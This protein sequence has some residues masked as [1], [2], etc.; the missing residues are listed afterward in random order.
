MPIKINQSSNAPEQAAPTLERLKIDYVPIDSVQLWKDNPREN[1]KAVPELMEGIKRHGLRTPLVVWGKNRYIYKGNTTWK[2]LRRLGYKEVPVILTSFK[3][4]AAAVDYGIDD[5]K[6]G[7]KAG[8]NVDLLRKLLVSRPAAQKPVSFTMK[9][10]SVLQKGIFG[11]M[12][13]KDKIPK[14]EEDLDTFEI[15]VSVPPKDKDRILHVINGALKMCGGGY[16]A[17]AY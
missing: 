9:E 3:H 5:N 6:L 10:F 8:W 7:E 4:E 11:Q 15:S 12:I 16:E 1:E 14:Y 13:P 2:A 17:A